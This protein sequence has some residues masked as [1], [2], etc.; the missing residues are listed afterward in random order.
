MKANTNFIK[1]TGIVLSVLTVLTLSTTTFAADKTNNG[2]EGRVDALEINAD[3]LEGL[4]NEVESL[5]SSIS[6]INDNTSSE[7]ENSKVVV[8]YTNSSYRFS[9]VLTAANECR[10]NF[11]PG[12]TLATTENLMNTISLSSILLPTSK[13]V[14]L[15]FS[16]VSTGGAVDKYTGTELHPSNTVVIDQNGRIYSTARNN[17]TFFLFTCAGIVR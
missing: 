10:E 4:S 8:G 6:S 16:G 5:A 11:G 14:I 15:P 17:R 13:S 1:S 2:L 9:G 3:K 7:N 12:T